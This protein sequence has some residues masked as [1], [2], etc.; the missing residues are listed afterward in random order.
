MLRNTVYYIDGYNKSYFFD[1]FQITMIAMLFLMFWLSLPEPCNGKPSW[2][3]LDIAGFGVS[4]CIE[5][6]SDIFYI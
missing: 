1:Y 6:V 2:Q 3:P 5:D 4:Q